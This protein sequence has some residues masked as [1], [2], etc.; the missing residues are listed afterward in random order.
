MVK[1]KM[2]NPYTGSRGTY[3]QCGDRE[4]TNKD[5][6]RQVLDELMSE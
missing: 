2:D 6:P 5:S 4:I 1:Q 3:R